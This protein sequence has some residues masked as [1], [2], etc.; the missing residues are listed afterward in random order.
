VRR[1]S[2]TLSFKPLLLL[3]LSPGSAASRKQ[4][5][6]A[7]LLEQ[8][9]MFE[10]SNLFP[11]HQLWQANVAQI[12]KASRPQ[13]RRCHEQENGDILPRMAPEWRDTG[14]PTRVIETGA[15]SASLQSCRSRCIGTERR[16]QCR[17]P[18]TF[19]PQCAPRGWID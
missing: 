18:S 8:P 10:L 12:L 4:I 17:L 19:S 13:S 6:D 15:A 9:L 2:L 3:A 7:R 14:T 16:R 1:S 11:A 5:K